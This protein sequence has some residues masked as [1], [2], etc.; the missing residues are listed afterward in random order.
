MI[1]TWCTKIWCTFLDVWYHSAPLPRKIRNSS[2]LPNTML[3]FRSIVSGY[4]ALNYVELL[5]DKSK[6]FFFLN[7]FISVNVHDIIK[8]KCT[9]FINFL[10]DSWI[11]YSEISEDCQRTDNYNQFPRSVAKIV[12]HCTKNVLIFMTDNLN[13]DTYL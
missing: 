1:Q 9:L 4:S 5:I 2:N 11:L 3:P 6:V 13:T 7:F 12:H 8:L 10:I